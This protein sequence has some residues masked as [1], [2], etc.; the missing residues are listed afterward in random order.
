ML[1]SACPA[2][3]LSLFLHLCQNHYL[4]PPF[5]QQLRLEV[6]KMLGVD[7]GVCLWET[8]SNCLCITWGS[9]LGFLCFSCFFL[10]PSFPSFLFIKL[11]FYQC[12]FLP[13]NL[14]HIPCCSVVSK[15]GVCVVHSYWSG[16]SLPQ[17]KK[18]FPSRKKKQNFCLWLL[19]V[20]PNSK[21]FWSSKVPGN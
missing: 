1:N 2:P 5:T 20:Y 14:L 12:S 3:R 13:S 17:G 11:S 8:V 4:L 19:V 15:Q 21:F 18:L 16:L 9:F 10:F 7:Y 6:G